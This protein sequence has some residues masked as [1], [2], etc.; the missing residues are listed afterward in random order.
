MKALVRLCGCAHSSEPLLIAYTLST[1]KFE[2][3]HEGFIFANFAYEKF[4][5]IK[6]FAKWQNHCVV[7]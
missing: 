6:P 3:F 2:K 7:Y 1:V 4:C 5:E